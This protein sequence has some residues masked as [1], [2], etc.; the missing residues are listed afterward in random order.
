MKFSEL[1]LDPDL[2]K[3][4]EHAGFVECMPVQEATYAH[5]FQ[6]RDIYV[7]SQ[8][9]TGK[10][11]AFI[12]SIFHLFLQKPEKKQKALI[13]A[14]TRELAV[15]IYE[16]AVLLGK[17]L[18]FRIGVFYGGVG[19]DRQ[20]RQLEEGVDII[21]GTPGRIID[22]NQSH[23]LNLKDVSVF[24]IDE[25]DRLFDMGFLPDIRK[26]LK[27]MPS[28]PD[29]QTMLF[30]ATLDYRVKTIASEYMHEPA[31]IEISPEQVTVDK[32]NQ[33]LFHVGKDQK[34]SLLVGILRKENPRNVII[35]TNMKRTAERL[36]ANMV[37][38][39]FACEYIIGDLPQKKRLKI[40]DDLKSGKLRYLIAT[41]VA[42]RG[43][44]VDDLEMVVNYDLPENSENYVHR[45]GRTARVG[46]TG[47]AISLVCEQYVYGLESIEQFAKVKIP[48]EWA[49]ES[50]YAEVKTVSFRR[51]P[52]ERE[53]RGE[54]GER[55]DRGE[56]GRGRDRRK[57]A[58]EAAAA[59]AAEKAP[60]QKPAVRPEDR[61]ADDVAKKKRKRR[62]KRPGTGAGAQEAAR[63]SAAA[64]PSNNRQREKREP[65]K[66]QRQEPRKPRPS[67]PAP[68]KKPASLLK[69]I[70]GI[71]TRKK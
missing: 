70:A 41:D 25:A 10:T 69:R 16:E 67:A 2:M 63:Q 56:R 46:K 55:R 11:G 61:P 17:Y 15:Q 54:R 50:L 71:F 21:I 43:L 35:F 18:K 29:R 22:F 32:I 9:G 14:P 44:H 23:K 26:L 28:Y 52:E 20:E 51:R 38:N 1:N 62:K 30:S 8:T 60:A 33:R 45:I 53:G 42:A 31:E 4:I 5:A 48:V 59:G 66:G 24:I 7:Q 34:L 68:E 36:A 64:S 27:K 57:P 58:R 37:H 19:Y 3:G 65:S 13:I 49:D 39:G 40:I 12:V 6:G 47:T